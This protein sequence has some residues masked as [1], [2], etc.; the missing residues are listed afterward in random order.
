MKFTD[1]MITSSKDA[2]EQVIEILAESKRKAFL[3]DVLGEIKFIGE[4][5][6]RT[7]LERVLEVNKSTATRFIKANQ[8]EL[9]EHGYDVEEGG[10]N[11]KSLVEDVGMDVH[12]IE[13]TVRHGR[14]T[15]EAV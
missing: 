5:I 14:Y 4:E 13:Q 7:E 8:A 6:T 12:I 11:G 1:N 9:E 15:V 3:Q 10:Q 2:R